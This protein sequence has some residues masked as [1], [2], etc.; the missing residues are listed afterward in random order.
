MALSKTILIIGSGGMAGHM[1]E[2][3]LSEESS[4]KVVGLKK[5]D[6]EINNGWKNHLEKVIDN[7]NPTHII[8]CIGILV[9][10]STEDPINAIKVN[11]LF[12]HDLAHLASSRGIKVIH[13]STDCWNDLSVYGR[14]K[15]AGEINYKDHLT[16]RTSI[17]GPELKNNGSGLFHWFLN[18]KDHVNGFS[19]HYWDGVTTLELAKFIAKQIESDDSSGIIDFR[20][21]EKTSKFELLNVL[22]QV[23]KKDIVIQEF[24]TVLVDK[25][26]NSPEFICEKSYMDQLNELKTWMDSHTALYRQYQD[27]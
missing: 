14:S 4:W 10:K 23:F 7:V 11:S 13:L 27:D 20:T 16:I 1:I 6:F 8:N 18:Q 22:Q 26:N 2:R 21:K 9:E 25:T 17:I 12:P 15:R 5:G 19:E 3:Y 24:K